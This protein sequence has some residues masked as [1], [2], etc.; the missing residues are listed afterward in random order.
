LKTTWDSHSGQT[1]RKASLTLSPSPLLYRSI[2]QIAV[3]HCQ[4]NGDAL[5][6]R[7]VDWYKALTACC[8]RLCPAPAP[9]D[10]P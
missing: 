6:R 3:Y 4:C 1:L 8:S 9:R 2:E 7:E 10:A 5:L